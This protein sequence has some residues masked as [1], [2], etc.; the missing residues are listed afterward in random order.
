MQ[1]G[2]GNAAAAPVRTDWLRWLQWQWWGL[3]Q[4]WTRWWLS[5]D[6]STQAAWL[7][8]LLGAQRRWLGLMVVAAA[9]MGLFVGLRLLRWKGRGDPMKQ[10]LRLLQRH[11]I[12]PMPGESFSAVCRRAATVHPD[13]AAQFLAVADAQQQ[14]AH[15]PLS[16]RERRW[17]QMVWRR[18]RRQ[19]AQRI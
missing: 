15:A 11:G 16:H 5:F 2:F 17:Q 7:E 12:T 18:C 6:Q 4:A 1:E 19:L 3:D 10:S 9:A 8:Q 13:L 14:L